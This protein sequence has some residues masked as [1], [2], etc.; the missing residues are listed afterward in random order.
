MF[1]I[2]EIQMQATIIVTEM[3]LNF[4]MKTITITVNKYKTKT[5]T[6][7]INKYIKVLDSVWIALTL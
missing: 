4:L 2:T 7:T 1:V 5:K 3:T 6:I